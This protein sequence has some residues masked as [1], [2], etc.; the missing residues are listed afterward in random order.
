MAKR[1]DCRACDLRKK[2]LRRPTTVARQ[3]VR[4]RETGR[5]G[6][7][8]F[9]SRMIERFDTARGRFLYSR[10]M[11][12]VEPVFANIGHALGLRRFSHRG[13]IKVDIQWKLF[14]MVHNLRK[15]A[16]YGVRFASGSA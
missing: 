1:T 9:T 16:S 5:D 6:T 3:V 15:V 4:F 2:C 12:I 11:G 13:R 7:R 8:S 14:G 10:R